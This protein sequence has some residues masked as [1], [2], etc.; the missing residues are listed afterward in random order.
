MLRFKK[1]HLQFAGK[2]SRAIKLYV[3]GCNAHLSY[4]PAFY[5]KSIGP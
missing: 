3:I 1:L 5:V 4:E 2:K